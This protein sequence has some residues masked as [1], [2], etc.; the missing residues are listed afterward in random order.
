MDDTF[1]H[2]DHCP[3]RSSVQ[4]AG[5][6][7]SIPTQRLS[8]SLP[9]F[10]NFSGSHEPDIVSSFSELPWNY[11]LF[12]RVYILQDCFFIINIIYFFTTDG[13][14]W[15]TNY[16]I[17]WDLHPV[18]HLQGKALDKLDSTSSIC[19]GD[20]EMIIDNV[21]EIVTTVSNKGSHN[22]YYCTVLD[23]C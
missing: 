9:S 1:P 19:Y 13:G 8:I 15:A 16:I 14:A 12:N 11:L 21:Y 22:Y 3:Q 17:D 5:L 20:V 7:L 6:S 2:P 23:A 4:K 18:Y 10:G